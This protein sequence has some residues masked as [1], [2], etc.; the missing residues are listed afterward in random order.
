MLY[1]P[2]RLSN[3]SQQAAAKPPVFSLNDRI[4]LLH[5]VFALASAGYTDISVALDLV[6]HLGKGEEDCKPNAQLFFFAYVFFNQ[7]TS[8]P[9]LAGYAGL[10]E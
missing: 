6:H 3:I 2:E 1:T 5:D 8:S 9:C 7:R 4:G 10:V